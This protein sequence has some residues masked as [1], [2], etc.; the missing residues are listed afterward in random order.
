[1]HLSRHPLIGASRRRLSRNSLGDIRARQETR[2]AEAEERVLTRD[3]N[4]EHIAF[5]KAS[6]LPLPGQTQPRSFV[7]SATT[8][9]PA[10]ASI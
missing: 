10:L 2:R 9:M 8:D 5:L 6:G 1:M 4:R 3:R 7:N